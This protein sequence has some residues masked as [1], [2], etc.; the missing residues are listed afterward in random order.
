MVGDC[1]HVK[2]V[3]WVEPEEVVTTILPDVPLAGVAL[4]WF[5]E[6]TVNEEL[7][8]PPKVTEVTLLKFT[9]VIIIGAVDNGPA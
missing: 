3:Y 1:T 6:T 5:D 7:G 9:P 2:P 8:V 4:I